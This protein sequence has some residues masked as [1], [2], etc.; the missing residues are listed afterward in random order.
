MRRQVAVLCTALCLLAL[1]AGVPQLARG[2]DPVAAPPRTGE[3][4]HPNAKKI[5][6]GNA[7]VVHA[8][9][10]TPLTGAIHIPPAQ[11]KKDKQKEQQ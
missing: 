10:G 6:E 5:N 1:L 8:G 2:A 4:A 3:R 11:V 7:R 9:P